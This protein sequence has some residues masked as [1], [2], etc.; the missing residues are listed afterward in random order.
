VA[1]TFL[2]HYNEL[3]GYSGDVLNPDL[4][5][6]L[7]QRAHRDILESR[8]WSFLHEEGVL[9]APEQIAV[10]TV[11]VTQFSTSVVVDATADAALAAVNMDIPMGTRQ[12]RVG[13]TDR[14]YNI[15]S[16]DTGTL[17]LTLKEPYSEE[18]ASGVAYSVFKCYY[19]PPKVNLEVDFLRFISVRDLENGRPLRLN[20]KKV[21]LD[22]RDPQR[23]S[24]EP[25]IV[26]SSYKP[27]ANGDPLFELWPLPTSARAYVAQFIRRGKELTADSDRLTY[28]LTDEL[29]ATRAQY[30]LCHWAEMNKG[31]HATLR[32]TDWRFLLGELSSRYERLLL[33]AKKQDDEIFNQ[34]VMFPRRWGS[35]YPP[36]ASWLQTHD[37]P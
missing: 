34:N 13:S 32:L 27:D 9:Q 26:V 24:T 4:A 21:D 8:S 15:D 30:H 1:K 10:G 14:I 36:S 11:T 35:E 12:F 33:N 25:P 3:I 37:W 18:S 2:D 19:L 22:R 7:V 23:S 28:P 5:K 16:Y 17:T 6:T 29:L 20:V 31:V